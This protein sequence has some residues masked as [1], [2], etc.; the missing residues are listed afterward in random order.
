MKGSKSK[1]H[2][3]GLRKSLVYLKDKENVAAPNE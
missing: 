3:H 1:I 2:A